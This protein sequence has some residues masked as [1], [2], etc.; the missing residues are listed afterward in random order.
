VITLVVRR[1]ARVVYIVY[2]EL[3]VAYFRVY[4]VEIFVWIS[5]RGSLGREYRPR[6]ISFRRGHRPMSL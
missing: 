4:D 5:Y 1:S 6:A 3:C 2:V